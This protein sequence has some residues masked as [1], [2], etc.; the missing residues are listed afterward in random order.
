MATRYWVIG[1]EYED[2]EFRALVPGTETMIGPFESERNARTEWLR[3]ACCVGGTS[4][5]TRYGI[6]AEPIR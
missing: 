4:A 5:T 3:L 6:A 1:G 2:P